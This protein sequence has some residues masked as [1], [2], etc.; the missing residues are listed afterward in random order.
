MLSD[1]A[2]LKKFSESRDKNYAFSQL[3]EK[4]SEP[5]YW[6]V[7]KRVKNHENTD[8]IVQNT[9]IKVWNNLHQFKGNSALFTWIY[10]IGQNETYTFL[11]SAYQRNY[12]PTDNPIIDKSTDN[13]L[14][15]EEIEKM[16][17]NAMESLP[18][19]QQIVFQMKY[20]DD[21]KFKE[22]AKYLDTSVGALK[23]SYHHAVKKIET[24]LEHHLNL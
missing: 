21:L 23:A 17:F 19:K 18:P 24:Y 9:W 11:S 6:S 14:T 10:K 4:Y 2:I 8:D 13:N 5:L 20:F 3:V 15:G 7:R 1:Q 16:L 22:I 12:F